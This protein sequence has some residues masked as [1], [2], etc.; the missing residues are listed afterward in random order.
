MDFFDTPVV[1]IELLACRPHWTSPLCEIGFSGRSVYQMTTPRE[2]A[3]GKGNCGRSNDRGKEA[4]ECHDSRARGFVSE[5]LMGRSCSSS[6]N[7]P[8]PTRML[9]GVGRVPGNGHP[10]PISAINQRPTPSRIW[11]I[12]GSRRVRSHFGLSFQIRPL[13]LRSKGD[14]STYFHRPILKKI[15]M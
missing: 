4:C 8:V 10:Y 12:Y 15:A 9:G 14:Q 7:R 5:E 3:L 11:A 13:L 1:G 6:L 2:Q